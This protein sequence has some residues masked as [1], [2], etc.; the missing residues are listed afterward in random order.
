M[1][2]YIFGLFSLL[3]FSHVTRSHQYSRS[4]KNI[5]L[6]SSFCLTCEPVV[7]TLSAVSHLFLLGKFGP[8]FL[9][10]A[11]LRFFTT[12][13]RSP[14]ILFAAVGNISSSRVPF[15]EVYLTEA[16][17]LAF[18]SLEIEGCALLH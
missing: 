18:I 8:N 11:F 9:P 5:G 16:L 15:S 1:N 12:V 17:T 2:I 10:I 14:S 6:A 3:F 13:C 7:C 4:E